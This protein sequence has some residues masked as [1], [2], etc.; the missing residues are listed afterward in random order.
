LAFAF[1]LLCTCVTLIPA[2]VSLPGCCKFLG[3]RK[4]ELLSKEMLPDDLRTQELAYQ[5]SVRMRLP[6]G[7]L[8]KKALVT[9]SSVSNAPRPKNA[10]SD[11]IVYD[12]SVEGHREFE[13][14]VEIV[15]P[16]TAKPGSKAGVGVD[17]LTYD[18]SARE[19]SV[20]PF[21]VEK[22][23][24]SVVIF[25]SH[26]S[27]YAMSTRSGIAMSPT[28]T[29][30]SNP[31][32]GG[33]ELMDMGTVEQI[34]RGDSAKAAK[35]G[36]AKS[37]E[38]FGI[39]ANTG[40]FIEQAVLEIP[41]LKALNGVATKLGVAFGFMQLAIDLASGDTQAASIN[42]A[43]NLG[44]SSVALWGSQA[45]QIGSVAVFIFDYTLTK[46]GETAWEGRTGLY[47]KAYALYYKEH[48]RKSSDWSKLILGI[49]DGAK[50]P[51][52]VHKG[53][54]NALQ[55]Y[56]TGFWDN[57]LVVAEY[58]E[59]VKKNDQTG[60]GGLNEKMKADI[61]A[62]YRAQIM[63]VLQE[64]VFPRIPI[65]I[66][67]RNRQ[68]ASQLL[69]ELRSGLDRMTTIEVTVRSKDSERS[70][71]NLDVQIA[72]SQEPDRWHGVT[73]KD[74]RWSMQC[75]TLG[76][77]SYGA[78]KKVKVT[79]PAEGSKEALTVEADLA[80]TPGK[81]T[82]VVDLDTAGNFVGKIDDV[83]VVPGADYPVKIVGPVTIA[84]TS[85]GKA[86]MN[87]SLKAQESAGKGAGVA[88]ISSTGKLT[89]TLVG[90][91]FNASGT[92]TST[93]TTKFKLPRG[94][95]LPPG[96][97]AGTSS[98]AINATGKLA[99][100]TITGTIQGAKGKP[101]RFEATRTAGSP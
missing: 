89:G 48:P 15:L 56:V 29:I 26:L 70:L 28:M 94:V 61:S 40:T 35:E 68:K 41:G 93:Y 96:A 65:I 9:I 81:T 27:P 74:G 18:E 49:I 24:K 91:A 22:D 100:D 39:A 84:V 54:E 11:P 13:E 45:L 63:H 5:G 53:I 51:D 42:A 90:A 12:F 55:S 79:V 92:V 99:G 10:A 64:T 75:T 52:D 46:T 59:R 69:G 44:Y 101:I 60:G 7:S 66:A 23:G 37:M 77:L 82:V 38:Y 14:P 80:Y 78:P 72:V 16:Y 87:F 86:T 21:A 62:A 67:N 43:K 88:D 32:L 83:Q 19:W 17:A 6:Y 97:G 20:M 58:L 33:N 2:I 71:K 47:Q 36:W 1:A 30:G 57:E 98:A 85:D 3:L 25:A 31:Y 34:L 76:Y 4:T 95:S 50:S 73:D 8:K